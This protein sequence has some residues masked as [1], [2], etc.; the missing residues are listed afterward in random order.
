MLKKFYEQAQGRL[1]YLEAQP[2]T[3]EMVVRKNELMLTMVAA[4]AILL[5]SLKPKKT[6]KVGK[7]IPGTGLKWKH[8]GSTWY[9]I[10]RDDN[11]VQFSVSEKALYLWDD[12]SFP[13]NSDIVFEECSKRTV[14]RRLLRHHNRKWNTRKKKVE[15]WT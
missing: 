15:L 11:S 8:N 9:G 14:A 13:Y 5:G 1:D 3:P 7:F 10:V 12:T 2:E 6:V 4:G